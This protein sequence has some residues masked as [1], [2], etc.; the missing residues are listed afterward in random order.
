MDG[1]ELDQRQPGPWWRPHIRRLHTNAKPHAVIQPNTLKDK[2]I[3]GLV[4]CILFVLS[5]LN[6]YTLKMTIYGAYACGVVG[7]ALLFWFYVIVPTFLAVVRLWFAYL[8]W[9]VSSDGFAIRLM[10]LQVNSDDVD[11]ELVQPTGHDLDP[12]VPVEVQLEALVEGESTEDRKRLR[13][14]LFRR[15]RK[16]TLVLK[17]VQHC[18]GALGTSLVDRPETR[19]ALDKRIRDFCAERCVR[20]CDRDNALPLAIAMY[21]IPLESEIQ[22]MHI[23]RG[24]FAW[25]QRY[26]LRGVWW[27][28][29]GVGSPA[30]NLE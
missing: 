9:L 13:R 26:R 20:H 18:R 19:M 23:E 1:A 24:W 21:F 30:E 5:S 14:Q 15:M 3:V 28:L 22:A 25:M 2:V 27:A 10:R 29:F 7:I 11:L 8:D 6:T 16:E 17:M 12:N 4:L